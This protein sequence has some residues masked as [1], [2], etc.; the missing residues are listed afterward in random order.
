MMSGHDMR[1]HIQ[2]LQDQLSR[3]R[4]RERK[5]NAELLVERQKNADLMDKLTSLKSIL[6]GETPCSK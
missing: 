1:V 6:E 3:A 2:D 5:L 4:Y